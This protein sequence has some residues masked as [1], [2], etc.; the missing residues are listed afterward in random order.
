MKWNWLHK[1]IGGIS[2]T[3]V[4]FIFQACYGTPQDIGNDVLVEGQV[5]SKTTGQPIKGIRV[6]SASGT[7]YQQTD[8]AGKFSFYSLYVRNLGLRF[9][10]IDSTLNGAFLAK[11]TILSDIAD[12]VWVDIKLEDK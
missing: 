3:S 8:D 7:Q 12:K 2:F 4:L 11:D 9:E 10:D 5:K 1:I 6:S